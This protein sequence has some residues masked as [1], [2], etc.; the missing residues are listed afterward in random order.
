M[1]IILLRVLMAWWAIPL[2][3]IIIAPAIWLTSEEYITPAME[4]TNLFWFGE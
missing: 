3:W 2:G 4:I 1:R